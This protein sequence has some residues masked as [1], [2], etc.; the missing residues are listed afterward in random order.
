MRLGGMTLFKSTVSTIFP[1]YFLKSND[2]STSN[3]TYDLNGLNAI[4]TNTIISLKRASSF[5]KFFSSI[6][7][8]K[9]SLY[10]LSSCF[11]I[12]A[13]SDE[14]TWQSNDDFFSISGALRFCQYPQHRLRSHTLIIFYIKITNHLSIYF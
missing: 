1:A 3:D 7:P 6:R 8:Y 5:F 13:F 12:L 4:F 14:I 11:S 2:S 9:D 10:G